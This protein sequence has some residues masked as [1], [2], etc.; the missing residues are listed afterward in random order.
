[1]KKRINFLISAALLFCAATTV[2]DDTEVYQSQFDS[3]NIRPKVLLLF[4]NSGSMDNNVTNQKPAYDASTTYS[5]QTGIQSGSIYWSTDGAVPSQN[6]T[7]WFND[8]KNR[9]EESDA[10]MSQIGYFQGKSRRWRPDVKRWDL[11]VPGMQNPQHVDCSAD[12]VNSNNTNDGSSDG[13][14]AT[15][16]DGPYVAA[17]DDSDIDWSGPSYTFFT[18]NYMNWFYGTSANTTRTRIDIAIETIKNLI[19]ANPGIDF[20]L[21][22]FNANFKYNSSTSNYDDG[23]RIIHRLIKDMTTTERSN[24][25]NMVEGLEG[26]T[27][28][29]LCETMWEA[30]LYLSGG[31]PKFMDE[32]NDGYISSASAGY[33]A[34]DSNAVDS[35][36]YKTPLGEC[37]YTYVIYMTDGYASLDTNA[38]SMVES[39]TGKTCVNIVADATT[40]DDVKNCLPELAEYMYNNDMDG[41]ATNGDQKVITYTIAFTL[42]HELMIKTA[43]LG[44]GKYYRADSATELAKAFQGAVTEILST[45]T[46][47]T[48]PS[49]GANSF[50]RTQSLDSVYMA[51]FKPSDGQRW[52]GNIKKFKIN[53]NG[54][55]IGKNGAVV[56]NKNNG[57]IKK[58]AKSFWNNVKDG[59][60]VEKGGAGAKLANRDLTKRKI[61]SN[62]A[63]KKWS[64]SNARFNVANFKNAIAEMGFADEAALYAHFG[65][66]SDTEFT[67]L[68]NWAR[69]FDVD[70]E[71]KDGDTNDNRPWIMADILHSQPVAINYGDTDGGGNTYSKTNPD[72]RL[73]FGTNEGFLH[74]INAANGNENWAFFPWELGP[75]LEEKRVDAAASQH[76]YGLDGRAAVWTYDKNNDGNIIKGDGDS[77]YVVIGMRRGGR[78]Y[79]AIDVSNPGSPV[80]KWRI[81]QSIPEFSELGQTWST[82]TV[83]TIPGYKDNAGNPKPVIIFGGGYDTNKDASGVG[84]VDSMGRAL[85]IVDIK[86]GALVWS[87]SPADNTANNMKETGLTHSVAADVAVL[88]SNGDKL[89]DR[90]YFGD[91]GGNLWRVDLPG[92][93]RPDA[94][95]DTWFIT[96]LAQLG[97]KDADRTDAN[98]AN[99]RR[100]FNQPDIVRTRASGYPYDGV[101]IG[102]GDRTNPNE[103]S[104]DNRFYVI[105]DKQLTPYT[106]APATS[107]SCGAV[108]DFRRCLPLDENDLYNATANKIQDGTTAQQQAAEQTLFS[109]T[110]HGLYIKLKKKGEKSLARSVS[111]SGQTFF[112]TYSPSASDEEPCEVQRG[113]GRLYHIDMHDA[114]AVIDYT[115]DS[116]VERKDRIVK[117][118]K[119]V[120]P[121]PSIY[122]DP[123]TGKVKLLFPF[124]SGKT[125]GKKGGTLETDMT[126]EKGKGVYWYQ[127]EY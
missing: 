114:R 118:G 51:M 98:L 83:T 48:T 84:T 22:L 73:V 116:T 21:G 91:T 41:D 107:G 70:D 96:Q 127:E 97:L 37:Q 40:G 14:P 124:G 94:S 109:A 108:R 106:S 29:P 13:Y 3:T 63:N 49:V 33:P 85:Y 82:P 8:S 28:T 126:L 78:A 32:W 46:T 90:I 26:N 99:D 20:G 87:I 30:Y 125:I 86:T 80:F 59:G 34:P 64:D 105:R 50:N 65:V 44:G 81:D 23:G 60:D 104:I 6:T 88:D 57:N 93:T 110:K 35:G 4:D 17:K 58:N 103:S 66:A 113:S 74:M 9:C 112:T 68:L 55:L 38:N 54:Q 24:L 47:F 18:A 42:D 102:S 45:N 77:A 101:L 79:Y 72:V 100:I 61:W 31:T 89:T 117:L 111:L 11:L 53:S 75:I 15:G 62:I 123:T 5:V 16:N 12:V 43:N 92:A 67:S 25:V 7:Q 69:G 119:D 122:V 121:P 95:Q 10:P 76:I 19:W 120:P 2:A 39:L 27:N 36:K 1:M 52:S 71:D 115:G 56:I